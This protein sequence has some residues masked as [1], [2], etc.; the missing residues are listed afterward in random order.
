MKHFLLYEVGNR[1]LTF[2]L[3]AI[4]LLGGPPASVWLVDYA[5]D[6]LIA[7]TTNSPFQTTA[8]YYHA[9]DTVD[10][11]VRRTANF[12]AMIT[13]SRLLR[14]TVPGTDLEEVV[15]RENIVPGVIEVGSHSM[16]VHIKLADNLVPGIYYYIFPTTFTYNG[17]AHNRLTRTKEF[18]VLPDDMTIDERI[19]DG[20]PGSLPRAR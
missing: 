20:S 19:S 10:F 3:L 4:A 15:S 2:A 13:G 1:L 6:K 12:E 14:R 18:E 5:K 7:V 9:R 16:L 17:H 8:H 11:V